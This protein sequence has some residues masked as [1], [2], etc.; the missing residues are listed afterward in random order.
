VIQ[1]RPSSALGVFTRNIR[2]TVAQQH[3]ARK[4]SSQ[5]PSQTLT[6]PLHGTFTIPRFYPTTSDA[7]I[8]DIDSAVAGHYGF[9]VQ[10][11]NFILN[12]EI[13][14]GLNRNT[15]SDDE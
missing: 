5:K 2:H 13:K 7:I 12:Y 4:N 1:R 14:Y 15:E 6:R 3:L 9:S 8:D 11:L 10:K